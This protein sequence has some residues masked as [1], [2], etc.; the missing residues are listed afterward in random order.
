MTALQE[1]VL[2]DLELAVEALMH[3]VTAQQ[4]KEVA[5]GLYLDGAATL[6]KKSQL[7]KLLRKTAEGTEENS[8]EERIL[9]LKSCNSPS[10]RL[11]YTGIVD[12]ENNNQVVILKRCN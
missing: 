1:Q 8:I 4:L 12:E 10:N 2:E 9:L 3:Q 11:T 7:M 6:S 5:T